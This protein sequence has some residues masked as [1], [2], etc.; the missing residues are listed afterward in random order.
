MIN[1]KADQFAILAF[2]S[3]LMWRAPL[4]HTL[5]SFISDEHLEGEL[6]RFLLGNSVKFPVSSSGLLGR[7]ISNGVPL[8]LSDRARLDSQLLKLAHGSKPAFISVR[9][10]ADGISV[11]NVLIPHSPGENGHKRKHSDLDEPVN[12]EWDANK[13]ING[14]TAAILPSADPMT[15]EIF[16]MLQKGTAR[17]KL[18]AEQVRYCGFV[19]CSAKLTIFLPVCFERRWIWAHMW[20][21]YQRCV[22]ESKN[23]EWDWT[24]WICLR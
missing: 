10:N 20:T 24:W 3:V 13:S 1:P 9:S 14:T 8:R 2:A 17:T 12:P 7:L 5:M 6:R 11:A 23:R 18:L 4:L 22:L 21:Y 16:S 19:G 15:Q